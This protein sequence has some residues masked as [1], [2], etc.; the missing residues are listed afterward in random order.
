MAAPKEPVWNIDPHTRAK[1]AI[2]RRYLQAW[3]PILARGRFPEVMYFDGFAGPGRYSDGEEGSPIIALRAARNQHIGPEVKLRFVFIEKNSSR[4]D[5]LKKTIKNFDIPEN[6]RIEIGHGEEFEEAFN[7]ILLSYGAKGLPPTFAFVDPFGW[8]GVPFS[9]IK[10]IMQYQHCEVLINFMY[11]EVNRF[12]GHQDQV[13]NF[14]R[15]FG[16]RKWQAGIRLSRANE[17]SRFFHNIY[18][19]QLRKGANA[20]FA[21]SFQMRNQ[22]DAVDYY[23][24]HATNHIRGLARMKEAMWK[25]DESGEFSFSDATDPDQLVL[26]EKEPRYEILR[27][28]ILRRFTGR[29][30][31]VGEVEE[32]VLAETAFRERHYK[33]QVLKPLEL[34]ARPIIEPVGSPPNRKRGTYGDRSLRLRFRSILP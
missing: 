29:V 22:N 20:R 8:S 7:R 14:D 17:R 28:Q 3:M 4:A 5:N 26:F 25:V 6:F 1:H 9:I 2:L 32:F 16:T 12:I 19:G 18:L 31:S 21:R 33:V 15:F 34:A 11:E 13:N 24:F 27:N 23:L 10:K 30:A